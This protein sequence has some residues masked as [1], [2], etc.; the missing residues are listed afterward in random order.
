MKNWKEENNGLE[1]EFEFKN[2]VEAWAF[3]SQVAL[4]SEKANHH[5]DWSN[6]YNKVK[7]RLSTHDQGNTITEKDKKLAEQI[8]ALM[9]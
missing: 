6:T 2:F 1:R 7:I 8:S 4:L 3:M 9:D 5:P